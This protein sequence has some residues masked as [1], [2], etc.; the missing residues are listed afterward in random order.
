MLAESSDP[1][2]ELAIVDML[3]YSL[4]RAE[5]NLPHKRKVFFLQAVIYIILLSFSFSLKTFCAKG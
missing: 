4:E 3:R 2:T 1:V 5:K